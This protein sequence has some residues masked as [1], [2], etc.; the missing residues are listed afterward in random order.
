[1]MDSVDVLLTVMK[2]G[3]VKYINIHIQ[4][5][6]LIANFTISFLSIKQG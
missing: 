6:V 5:N 3:I 2:Y 4:S 1:M